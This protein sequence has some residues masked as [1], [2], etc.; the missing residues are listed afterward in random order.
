MHQQALLVDVMFVC[1]R[2][3]S[4]TGGGARREGRQQQRGD[5]DHVA[6]STVHPAAFCSTCYTADD[7]Q[8]LDILGH[9]EDRAGQ[10]DAKTYNVALSA[11]G[12]CGR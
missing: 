7:D 4:E 2:K 5:I 6:H 10:L 3:K 8:V 11:L 9:W 12:K 1:G